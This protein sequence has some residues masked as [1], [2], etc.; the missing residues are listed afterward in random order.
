MSSNVRVLV[1]KKDALLHQGQTLSR[2]LILEQSV[3]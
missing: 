3:P 1:W 2:P